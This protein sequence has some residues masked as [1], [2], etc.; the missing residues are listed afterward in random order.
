M[1]EE[2]FKQQLLDELATALHD[3]PEALRWLMAY[4]NYAHKIDDIVD[5]PKDE[6]IIR[7]AFALGEAMF[8]SEF[9]RQH[10]SYL[11]PVLRTVHFDYFI[12]EEWEKAGEI[13][14]VQHADQIR[15]CGNSVAVAVL[16]LFC[17]DS[18]TMAVAKKLKEFSQE[19]HHDKQQDNLAR[20]MSIPLGA[21]A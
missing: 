5:E 9:W 14:K 15:H 21:H 11:Y 8:A 1:T 3:H 12:S 7:E 17:E 13:W 19:W 16:T 20:C 10:A 4:F 18:V 6:K 2:Q